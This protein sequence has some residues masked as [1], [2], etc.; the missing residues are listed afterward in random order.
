MHWYSELETASAID[1]KKAE[2]IMVTLLLAFATDE[3]FLR[4]Y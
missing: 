2:V 4:E 3:V 1:N